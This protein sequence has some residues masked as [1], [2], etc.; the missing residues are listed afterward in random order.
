M[1]CRRIDSRYWQSFRSC[2]SG[3]VHARERDAARCSADTADILQEA[4]KISFAAQQLDE[5]N[6]QKH[7]S[8]LLNSGRLNN[9]LELQ[10]RI[11]SVRQAM[12]RS[13]VGRMYAGAC[14]AK[15]V[16]KTVWS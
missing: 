8:H 6:L 15:A 16:E 2:S 14:T 12:A 7:K 1:C 4:L 5:H 11:P 3:A 9:Q 10:A 13:G